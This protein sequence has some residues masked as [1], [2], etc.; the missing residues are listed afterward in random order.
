[1]NNLDPAAFQQ[2]AEEMASEHGLEQDRVFAVLSQAEYQQAIIDAITSPAEALPWHRYRPIFLT[3]SRIDEGV[4]F[5]NEYQETLNRASTEYGV[6]PRIMVAIIGVE[7]RYGRH[8]G[9]YRVLDALRTLAFDYP[10]RAGFFRRE[11]KQ[12]FLLTREEGIDPA[13]PLG[14]Y[15]GAMGIPQFISSSYRA[16]AV[17][18]NK[19]GR[20]DLWDEVPDA[21]GSVANYFDRHGWQPDAPVVDPVSVSGTAW[22]SLLNN[23]L[24]PRSTVAALRR[25]GVAVPERVSGDRSV[26]LL[27]LEGENGP[28]YYA[29]Y[30]NFYVVTRYNHSPLYAMAVHQLAEAIAARRGEP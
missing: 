20:R 2:F 3:D 19:N 24:R 26:K 14:S 28:E 17:D 22:R 13:E 25:A 8:R 23:D 15:A 16:Y 10:P 27:E 4:A 1:M 29:A 11:L 7:S 6:P 18:L 21:V 9:R 12:Y 30:G 5:W